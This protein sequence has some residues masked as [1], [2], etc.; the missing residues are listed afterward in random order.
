MKK[1]LINL[2]LSIASICFL[3]LFFCLCSLIP[4]ESVSDAGFGV[5]FFFVAIIMFLVKSV[6]DLYYSIKDLK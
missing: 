2:F 6:S 4:K 1:I 5:L 3:V